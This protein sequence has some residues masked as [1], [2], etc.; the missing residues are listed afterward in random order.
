MPVFVNSSFVLIPFNCE[1]HSKLIGNL[2]HLLEGPFCQE[3]GV[4]F[5]TS[6]LL[7]ELLSKD[8]SLWSLHGC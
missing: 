2:M 1:A 3:V 6:E 5:E 8:L 4:S 7:L